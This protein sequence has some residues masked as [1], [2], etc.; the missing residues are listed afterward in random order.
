MQ[1]EVI[2]EKSALVMKNPEKHAV[3]LAKELVNNKAELKEVAK[4]S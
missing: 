2:R 1:K 3:E 4:C